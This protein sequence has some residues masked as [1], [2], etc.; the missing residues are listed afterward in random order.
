MMT[1]IQI[2]DYYID[3]LDTYN[4]PACK[5]GLALAIDDFVTEKTKPLEAEIKEHKTHIENL[6]DQIQFLEGRLESRTAINNG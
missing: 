2:A 1:S 3:N 4:K 6:Q 5:V